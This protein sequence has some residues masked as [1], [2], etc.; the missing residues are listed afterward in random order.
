MDRRLA[1]QVAEDAPALCQS[2]VARLVRGMLATDPDMIGSAAAEL[3]ATGRHMA[4]AFAREELACA[5]GGREAAVTA[6]EGALA[7]YQRMGAQ[8]D[9]GP[10]PGPA[11]GPGR[12]PRSPRGAS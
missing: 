6:L 10:A 12:A 9:R 8:P 5:A 1:G 11:A 4:E 2:H 3:Q 7:G